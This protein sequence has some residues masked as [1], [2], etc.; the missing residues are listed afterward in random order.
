MVNT[1]TEVLRDVI[2]VNKP[3][4]FSKFKLL[5][6][7]FAFFLTLT[8]SVVSVASTRTFMPTACASPVAWGVLDLELPIPFG[9]LSPYKSS[10]LYYLLEKRIKTTHNYLAYVLYGAFSN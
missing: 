6:P 2:D 3:E 10:M 8:V 1:A 7:E 4:P 5:K 9:K